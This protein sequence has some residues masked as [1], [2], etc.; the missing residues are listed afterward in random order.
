MLPLLLTAPCPTHQ[1]QR[2]RR[3]E[4]VSLWACPG[5]PGLDND[6]E[7]PCWSVVLDE[8][9][10]R[11]PDGGDVKDLREVQEGSAIALEIGGVTRPAI[12]TE[13]TR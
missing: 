13:E 6:L 11:D 12:T 4:E 2:F 9:V 7:G 8:D 1:V 10:A 3:R 5:F